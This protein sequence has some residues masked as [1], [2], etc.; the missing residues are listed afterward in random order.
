[1]LAALVMP[2]GFKAYAQGGS[3]KLPPLPKPKTTP[4]PKPRA[5]AT[6]KPNTSVTST[7]LFREPA[8][9]PPIT[10]NQ[11]ADGNL[12]P[13][14]AGRQTQN[15]YY[16]EYALTALG[17]ELLTIQLQSA[18]TTLAVQV[19]DKEKNGLAILKDPRT[20]EFKLDTPDGGLPPGDG[21]YRVR[22]QI[23]NVEAS[24]API[25]YTLKLNLTGVTDDGYHARLQQLIIAFNASDD[26]GADV[27]ITKLEQL[28]RD[29]PRKSGAY[30]RL[31]MLYLYHRH[32][33]TQALTQMEQAI[34]LGGAAI[35]QISHDSQW[36]QPA[37]KGKAVTWKDQR[38]GLLNIRSE[39]IEITDSNGASL[40]STS[41][42]Q[43]KEIKPLKDAPVIEIKEGAR[44]QSRYFAPSSNDQA[45]V[46]AIINLI[47]T[48][49]LRKG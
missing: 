38:G 2:A 11:S 8:N 33:L 44:N 14:T 43:I 31:G 21:E 46:E 34:K 24:A 10:F 28:A 5:S 29:E 47:K 18:N 37:T 9:I 19:L 25:A 41:G 42:R 3:G 32:D 6:P 49:V 20:G 30:E 17:G 45:E 15:S 36:R 16:D 27:A 23:P 13:K 22:V 39:Q 48:H 7:N 26:K 35:F 12:D 4:T 40:L 1:M